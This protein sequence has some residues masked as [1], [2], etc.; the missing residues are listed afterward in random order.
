MGMKRV[1]C[2]CG[3]NA[4][5]P[6]LIRAHTSKGVYA[7]QEFALRQIH[8]REAA[9]LREQSCWPP[10]AMLKSIK[11]AAL[12]WTRSMKQR[13]SRQ[14]LR[15]LQECDQPLLKSSIIEPSQFRWARWVKPVPH[16][17]VTACV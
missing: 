16:A 10:A 9:L 15:G 2:Y 8:L 12:F 4:D 7:K 6:D 5:F 17:S 13:Y 14:L 3:P 11:E 1:L